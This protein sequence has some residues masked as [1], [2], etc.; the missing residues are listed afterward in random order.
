MAASTPTMTTT[1]ITSSKVKPRV[2][3]RAM[4]VS[5]FDD[6]EC[7]ALNFRLLGQSDGRP[8]GGDRR[9]DGCCR[10][11]RQAVEASQP[12]P[13]ARVGY[14]SAER[15]ARRIMANPRGSALLSVCF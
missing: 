9:R 10:W 7:K 13:P 8:N 15:T 4:Q 6:L 2:R 14:Q 5:P 11:S 1:I 3:L 12:R